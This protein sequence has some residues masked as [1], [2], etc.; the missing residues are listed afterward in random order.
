MKYQKK[1]KSK[2]KKEISERMKAKTM[3]ELK[4][5]RTRK[6]SG[7]DNVS[8]RQCQGQILSGSS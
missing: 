1:K 4:C 7:S 3:S 2:K 6:I 8:V 5:F